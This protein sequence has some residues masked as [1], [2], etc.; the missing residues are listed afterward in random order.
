MRFQS[1][2]S[3]SKA[4][5]TAVMDGR[6]GVCLSPAA[7]A[8]RSAVI[9]AQTVNVCMRLN[10]M[11]CYGVNHFFLKEEHMTRD[12][13]IRYVCCSRNMLFS[14]VHSVEPLPILLL[15]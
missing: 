11:L 15:I 13:K 6:G 14:T 4:T 10:Y 2:I 8:Q 3:I 12:L 7:E 5:L 1:G 9:Q